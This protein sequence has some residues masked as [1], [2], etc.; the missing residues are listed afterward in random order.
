[1]QQK[2]D[3]FIGKYGKYQNLGLCNQGGMGKIFSCKVLE[4]DNHQYIQDI[5]TQF[6][7]QNIMV[8]SVEIG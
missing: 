8:N 4:F 1:M 7:N 5:E 2:N 3:I 6:P